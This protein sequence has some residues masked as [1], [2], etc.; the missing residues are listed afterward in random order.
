ME[1]SLLRALFHAQLYG[2]VEGEVAYATAFVADRPFARLRVVV[3]AV[4]FVAGL[5]DLSV[6]VEATPACS[7]PSLTARVCTP[8]DPTTPVSHE[9]MRCCSALFFP[10][11]QV[12]LDLHQVDNLITF[13]DLIPINFVISSWSSEG[14][15]AT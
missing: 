4:V 2:A 6:A 10:A 11:K 13:Q 8:T 7:T 3:G 9:R 12:V 14:R 15:T 1:I 5:L